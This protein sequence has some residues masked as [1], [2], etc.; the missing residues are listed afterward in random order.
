MTK[1]KRM[2]WHEY[3]MALRRGLNVKDGE[4]RPDIDAAIRNEMQ[5]EQPA[6]LLLSRVRA[7]LNLVR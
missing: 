7:K 4:Q 1:P 2:T 6:W 3:F 5:H